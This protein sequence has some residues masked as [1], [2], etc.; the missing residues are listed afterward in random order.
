MYALRRAPLQHNDPRR[1]N[2]N[3]TGQTENVCA[4][5]PFVWIYGTHFV[6]I[7]SAFGRPDPSRTRGNW[8]HQYVD[9]EWICPPG[10]RAFISWGTEDCN[11]FQVS[12]EESNSHPPYQISYVHCCLN[13]PFISTSVCAP[14]WSYAWAFDDFLISMFPAILY[15]YYVSINNIILCVS[16]ELQ[17]L[18]D[19]QFDLRMWTNDTHNMQKHAFFKC[20]SSAA[21]RAELARTLRVNEFDPPI[22][23]RGAS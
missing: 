16:F 20:L 8:F 15:W 22:I 9:C 10:G 17:R 7:T 3:R 6:E 1:S 11:A 2:T 18:L 12:I 21:E 13:C 23:S 5:V 4:C 14:I 19:V